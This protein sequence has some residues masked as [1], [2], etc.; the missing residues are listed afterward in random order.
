MKFQVFTKIEVSFSFNSLTNMQNRTCVFQFCFTCGT[1]SH[2]EAQIYL[3]FFPF[4]SLL[5]VLNSNYTYMQIVSFP[6]R[7]IQNYGSEQPLVT[8]LYQGKFGY[9][10]KKDTDCD[11]MKHS[12][13]HYWSQQLQLEL[14]YPDSNGQ[15][16]L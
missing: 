5:L 16:C 7:E 3:K 13:Q 4:Y 15:L 1:S 10:R 12:N 9:L 14:I 6:A 11:L 2:K 8:L